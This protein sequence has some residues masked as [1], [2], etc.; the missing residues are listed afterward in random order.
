MF[1]DFAAPVLSFIEGLRLNGVLRLR[2]ATLRT[3]G[4]GTVN[5]RSS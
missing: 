3:N 5:F 2:F 4:V 1:F